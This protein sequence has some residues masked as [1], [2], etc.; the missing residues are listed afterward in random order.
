MTYCEYR[1]LYHVAVTSS[2]PDLFGS[3]V[4]YQAVGEHL[5][6]PGCHGS[7]EET[8]TVYQNWSWIQWER[9]EIRWQQ[10][11]VADGAWEKGKFVHICMTLQWYES[12]RLSIWTR[13]FSQMAKRNRTLTMKC[14]MKH[15]QTRCATPFL[16]WIPLELGQQV[17]DTSGGSV[18]SFDKQQGLSTQPFQFGDFFCLFLLFLI[19]AEAY[20]RWRLPKEKSAWSF[21]SGKQC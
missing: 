10:I 12:S 19:A 13:V 16:Q 7:I 17:S 4:G 15:N 5:V 2:A 11:P 1:R 21:T 3:S 9:L 14:L 20:S 8:R 18:V 6:L